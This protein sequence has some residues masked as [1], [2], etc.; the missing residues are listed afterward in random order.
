V[1]R[2]SP[3]GR[4]MSKLSRDK[5]A[6]REREIVAA[7][8]KIGVHA[9]KVPLSG[10]A[11]YQGNG[12]DVDVYPWG[13]EGAPLCGEVKARGSGGGFVQIEKWLSDSDVMFLVRDQ[14]LPGKPAPAPLVVLP[15]AT[16]TRLI[17]KPEQ[18]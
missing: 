14:E 3:L 18:P 7:H 13:K 16:W 5:G 10:A 15:W 9:E 12:S 11:R 4:A 2:R 1:Q 17:K 6:R 8:L